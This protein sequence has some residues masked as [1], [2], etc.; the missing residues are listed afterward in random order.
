VTA[1]FCLFS[2]FV[3]LDLERMF[4]VAMSEIGLEFVSAVGAEFS[5]AKG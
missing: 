3:E 4:Q 1:R 2:A 5:A